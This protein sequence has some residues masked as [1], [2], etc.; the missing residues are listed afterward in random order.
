MFKRKQKIGELERALGWQ[1][2]GPE[3]FAGKYGSPTGFGHT[4]FT[5]T[6]LWVDPE[7]ELVVVLL[8][9]RVHPTRANEKI[10]QVR[11]AVHNAV[12]EGLGLTPQM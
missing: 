2:P 3:G 4:G 7:K 6:S 8:T 11:P 1:V 10:E 12:Y 9:N 5:G